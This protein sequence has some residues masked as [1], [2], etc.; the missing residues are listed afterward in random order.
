MKRLLQIFKT[1]EKFEFRVLIK[2]CFLMGK[3]Y[4][5]AKQWLD[6]CY[7]DSAL[8]E[9]MVKRWY[10]DIKR[11]RTDTNDAESSGHPNLAV[12]LET[13]KK[14]HKLVLAYRKLKLR[15]IAEELKISEGSEFTILHKHLSIRKLCSKWVPHLLTVD[16]KQCVDDSERCLQPF[17][18]NKKEFSCKYVTMKETWIHHFISESNQQSAEWTA[19]G[20]SHPKRPSTSK[21][22]TFVFWDAK[23][24]LFIN[25]L[26]KGRTIN[27][28]YYIA[29][30]EHLKEEITVSQVNY[31]DGKTTWIGLR[32]ASAPT[33]FSRSGPSDN[34]LLADLKR[35]L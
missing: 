33:W 13:T 19:A 7:L 29:L 31:N 2:H 5:Q 14:L 18:H 11:S 9:T 32:I 23:D 4:V 25:Y 27:S 15:E 12:A 8:S 24:I 28:E 17:Q 3:K 34:W 16:Q 35:M 10:T 21:V 1:M 20:E 26:D 22:L 30:L 6:K